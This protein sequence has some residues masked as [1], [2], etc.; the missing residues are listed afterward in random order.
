[1]EEQAAAVEAEAPPARLPSREA[2]YRAS[3]NK[4]FP[5]AMALPRA[6]HLPRRPPFVVRLRG[7]QALRQAI[8]VAEILGPPRAFD[9]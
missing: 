2:V 4:A 9:L 1:M 3:L 7:R 5:A 6:S 8:V